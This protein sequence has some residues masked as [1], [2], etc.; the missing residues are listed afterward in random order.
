MATI[1]EL[2]AELSRRREKPKELSLADIQGEITRRQQA[3]VQAQQAQ[4]QQQAESVAEGVGPGQA[5]LIGIGRGLTTIGRGLGFAEPEAPVATRAIKALEEQ[6]PVATIGGQIL[7]EA[8]PFL[9]PGAPLGAIASLPLRVLGGATLGAAEGGIISRGLDG[10]GKEQAKAGIIGGVLAGGAEALFPVIGRL[11]GAFIRKVTGQAPKGALLD[12]S[13]LPT[14]ELQSALTREGVSFD[15]LSQDAQK[16]LDASPGAA[17]QEAARKAFLETQGITPTK[18][19]ITRDAETF[20][21]QQEAAKTSGRVRDALEQQEAVLT[22]SFNQAVLETGG[23]ADTPTSA[24]S[25]ALVGKATILDDNISALYKRAREVS[26]GEKNVKFNSLAAKLRELA[27]QNRVTGGAIEAIVGDLQAKGVLNKKMKVIG[28]IDVETSEDVRK[29]MNELF[30]PQNGF[31]NGVLRQLKDTLDDD[32]FKAAGEDV[33]KQGRKAKHEFEKEL[34]RAKIS[35]FDSR[36]ANLVRDVLE[37]KISPDTFT[38]DVVFSKKWRAADIQQLKDYISTDIDG[39]I[40]F[41]D[42]RADTLNKIKDGAFIGPADGDGFQALSRDKL[43]SQLK[44]IGKQK[45]AVLFTPQEQKFLDDMLKV[46]SLREPVRATAQGRGPSAQAIVRLEKKLSDLPLI[47]G[48]IDFIDFDAQ[49]RL[50]IKSRPAVT[51]RAPTA[52]ERELPGLA[53]PLGIAASVSAS[54]EQQ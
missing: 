51:P 21:A 43:E 41:D 35:K 29:L 34:T 30:D 28:K 48:I 12:A 45:L 20:Q 27:P 54:Q 26:P 6:Q 52:L 42:L 36:K 14:P 47:G 2:Q 39:K 24:V 23:Q 10:S 9:I 22:S 8:A 38:N 4:Q 3:G 13:G 18:A 15:D 19:Q 53:A 31:R 1:E 46:S 50:A 37:N 7:G 11:G 17:P 5:A 25:D 32:V 40:A 33:F 16:L 44:K 49:G